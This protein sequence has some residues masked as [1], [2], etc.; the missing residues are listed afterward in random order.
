M[1]NI[2]TILLN[3]IKNTDD[4]N[5]IFITKLLLSNIATIWLTKDFSTIESFIRDNLNNSSKYHVFLNKIKE[6]IGH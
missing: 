5:E 3:K 4:I 6:V 1:N 2:E